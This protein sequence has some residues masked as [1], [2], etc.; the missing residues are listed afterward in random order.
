MSDEFVFSTT[1]TA[2]RDQVL[3]AEPTERTNTRLLVWLYRSE[4][5]IALD[6]DRNFP[7]RLQKD[8]HHFLAARE[9]HEV[10]DFGRAL[11]KIATVRI[12][13]HE[14]EGA[15]TVVNRNLTCGL[16]ESAHQ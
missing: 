12:K 10:D 16:V 9:P 14:R 13:N 1:S 4:H 7:T 11:G 8:C 6:G 3:T 5:L 2:T 15:K